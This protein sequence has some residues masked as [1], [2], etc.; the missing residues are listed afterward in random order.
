MKPIGQSK[1]HRQEKHKVLI[2][3]EEEANLG[4][5]LLVPIS[6]HRSTRHSQIQ[7]MRRELILALR[8][9]RYIASHCAH[10]SLIES[11]RDEWKFIATVIDRLQFVIFL[12]V[13]VVGTLALLNQVG[14][15]QSFVKTHTRF[16]FDLGT[17]FIQIKS[18]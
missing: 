12:T 16:F 9:I 18:E 5:Q 15:F 10:E 6:T 7:Q 3:E 11:I 1:H 13:T 8:N 14:Q 4:D 2:E 17:G